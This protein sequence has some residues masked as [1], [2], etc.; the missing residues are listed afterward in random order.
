MD[1]L[2][3]VGILASFILPFFNIPLI[4]RIVRRKSANDIS[5]SWV[6]GVWVCIVLMT[7]TAVASSDTTFRIFGVTNLVLF[8]FVAYFTFKYRL[9]ESKK[10]P[11]ESF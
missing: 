11:P 10:N 3:K 4:I 6:A 8:T 2:V 1:Y 5:L 7:P 9:L